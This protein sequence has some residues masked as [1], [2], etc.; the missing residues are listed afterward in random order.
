MRSSR[1]IEDSLHNL[2][3]ILQFF[4]VLTVLMSL[5]AQAQVKGAGPAYAKG[6]AVSALPGDDNGGH[7][8]GIRVQT[9]ASGTH[10]DTP[11]QRVSIVESYGRVPL[12]FEANQGQ[13]DPHVKFVSRG[14]G[15]GLFLTTSEAV[16]TKVGKSSWKQRR[17]SCG[18]AH[19]K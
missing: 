11:V 13:T 19:H 5:A 2:R 9:V 18:P 3:G 6:H 1:T 16:L 8:S 12:A 4:G 14:P 7:V 15:Y 10:P 17:S